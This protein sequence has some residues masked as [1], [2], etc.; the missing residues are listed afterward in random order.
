[1]KKKIIEGE[2]IDIIDD[3]GCEEVGESAPK[4]SSSKSVIDIDAE[5]IEIEPEII[6]V[7]PFNEPVHASKA[8]PQRFK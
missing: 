6:E 7:D 1:M 3:D 5:D 8:P 4:N 2:R